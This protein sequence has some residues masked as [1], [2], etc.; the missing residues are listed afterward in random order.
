MS[1]KYNR[2]PNTHCSVCSKPIY[3]RPSQIK[4]NNNHVYC[5]S[6]CYGIACRIM[7]PCKICGK[8]MMSG[9]NKTTCSRECSNKNRTG[10]K[11]TRQRRK[12]NVSNYKFLKI[13]LLETRGNCCEICGY[14][15]TEILQ[16]HHKDKN[17]QNN[18]LSNL[19]LICP[20]C[21][22]EKHFLKRS[23]LK[24]QIW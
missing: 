9:A 17:R 20:N 4:I 8:P 24:N 22:F 21:H 11:Y 10:I 6:D 16:V 18:E 1:E 23:W 19:E 5:S 2:R 7:I 3:K 12:D 15:K 13:R 14:S